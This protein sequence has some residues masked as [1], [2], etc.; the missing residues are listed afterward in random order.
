ML[1]Q[2]IAW[3]SQG[4]RPRRRLEADCRLLML[5]RR[6]QSPPDLSGA[7]T[8]VGV[9]KRVLKTGATRGYFLGGDRLTQIS[10]YQLA[11]V[12][13]AIRLLNS[14]QIPNCLGKAIFGVV[15]VSI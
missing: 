3:V 14:S 15:E 10:I 2:W 7:Y 6:Q 4:R 9:G 8:G 12:S 5:G 11:T 1:W 13:S